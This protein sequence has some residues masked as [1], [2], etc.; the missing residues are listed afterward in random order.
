MIVAA[1]V[2]KLLAV[3]LVNVALKIVVVK[4]VTIRHASI[5]ATT[6]DVFAVTVIHV[7]D[8]FAMMTSDSV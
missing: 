4:A 7:E 8:L 1:E 3:I 5:I 6:A 2:A